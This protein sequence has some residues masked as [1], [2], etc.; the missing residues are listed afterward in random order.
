MQVAQL[1][2]PLEGRPSADPGGSASEGDSLEAEMAKVSEPLCEFLCCVVHAERCV[3]CVW[4]GSR[5]TGRAMHV[6]LVRCGDNAPLACVTFPF[7]LHDC[8]FSF[9]S[10]M[11]NL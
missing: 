7:H 8:T 2:A 10:N 5:G 11:H 9:S 6:C 3:L 4:L 1:A